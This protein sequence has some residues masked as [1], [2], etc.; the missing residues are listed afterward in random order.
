MISNGVMKTN[1][2]EGMAVWYKVA[3]SC[4]GDDCGAIVALEFDKDF[5]DVSVTFYKKVIWTDK[6]VGFFTNAYRRI[7]EAI[8]ILVHGYSEYDGEF[9][10][11]GVDR[12]DTF[13]EALNEGRV[14]ALEWKKKYDESK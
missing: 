1:E 8:K 12:L 13:I 2:W 5:G 9:I 14:K 3:C 7:K 11:D 6:R 4:I 10:I